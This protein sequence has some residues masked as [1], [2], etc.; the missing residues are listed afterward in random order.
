MALAVAAAWAWARVMD[1]DAWRRGRLPTGKALAAAAA[2]G[3]V[4]WVVL[5]SSVF[6]NFAGLWDSIR[7]YAYYCHRARGGNPH[8]HPWHFYLRLLLWFKHGNGP[9]WSEA[10]ILVLALAGV[11]AALRKGQNS[12]A[13]FLA[14]YTLAMTAAYAIIP[15]KTPWCMLSFLYGM[16]LCAGMGAAALVG[17]VPTRWGKATVCVLLAAGASHLGWQAYRASYPLCAHP[18]N[19]YVYAHTGRDILRLPARMEALAAVH[20]QG[21]GMVIKAVSR[22]Q[23]YWPLPWYL[24]K[25]PNVGYW[26][27]P[28]EDADAAVVIT[29][30]DMADAV[31]ARLRGDYLVEHCGLRPGV[32]LLIYVQRDLWDKYL[33]GRG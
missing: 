5:F 29:T 31:E 10:L 26:T 1:Q 27:E 7:T 3:V 23:D 32:L 15:Y 18:W 20:P 17:S 9:V 19:P 11:V 2:A 6:T 21:R 25:F 4:V 13:R 28:P 22:P 8:I 30:H 16:V 14:F 24:R 12:L 33:A